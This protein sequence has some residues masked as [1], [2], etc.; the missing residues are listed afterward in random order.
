M[1][2]LKVEIQPQKW[3]NLE[4]TYHGCPDR[5]HQQF[6]QKKL[7][8]KTEEYNEI[9]K[10]MQVLEQLLSA[11][12]EGEKGQI[13]NV[14][15]E[16]LSLRRE[17]NVAKNKIISLQKDIFALNSELNQI[18]IEIQVREEKDL[19]TIK[20]ISNVDKNVRERRKELE[21]LES[22]LYV[23]NK[24]RE[25]LDQF[26]IQVKEELKT[27]KD[28]LEDIEK[29]HK[30]LSE[31]S[32]FYRRE[33]GMYKK[34]VSWNTRPILWLLR[35]SKKQHEKGNGEKA[36]K[37]F[38]KAKERYLKLNNAERKVIDTEFNEM[39]AMVQ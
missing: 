2:D 22:T 38:L 27:S 34:M 21:K 18:K 28:Q 12:E 1:T 7:D 5:Q 19:Q 26:F 10:K 16:N 37:N 33:L 35:K 8:E 3:K 24:E 32:D 9:H 29:K 25:A 20:E 15:I 13:D 17:L 23:R 30:Q 36:L 31:E 11:K 14:I 39:M 4:C 6:L